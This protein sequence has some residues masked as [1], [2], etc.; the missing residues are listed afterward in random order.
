MWYNVCSLDSRT[1]G[2]FLLSAGDRVAFNPINYCRVKLPLLGG[3][4]VPADCLSN[5]G[6]PSKGCFIMDI[7]TPIPI[8]D[9]VL[10]LAIYEAHKGL[11]F[12]TGRRVEF[13]DM[14]VDHVLPRARGGQDCIANYV[15]TYFELNSRKNDRIDALLL[16]RMLYINKIVFADKALRIYLNSETPNP[17]RHKEKVALVKAHSKALSDVDIAEAR[18]IAT[19]LYIQ[20]AGYYSAAKLLGNPTWRASLYRLIN[21]PGFRP[22]DTFIEILLSRGKIDLEDYPDSIL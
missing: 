11:C 13:P 9:K 5:T 7:Y 4:C 16:E 20:S 1:R 14:V 10:R 12:Y 21:E 8:N 6:E 22:S 2:V 17:H 19:R 3:P 15:L 18:E